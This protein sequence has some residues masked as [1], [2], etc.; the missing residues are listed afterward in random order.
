ME[1]RFVMRG[2]KR[3]AFVRY[4]L[5]AGGREDGVFFH[6]DGWCVWVGEERPVCLGSLILPEVEVVFHFHEG[7]REAVLWRFKM[8][9]LTAGG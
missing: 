1:E 5:E 6:H 3:S 8:R 2:H 9:F 7:Q 4:F